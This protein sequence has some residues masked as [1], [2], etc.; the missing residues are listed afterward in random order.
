MVARKEEIQFII[1]NG[2]ITGHVNYTDDEIY[3]LDQVVIPEGVTG[4]G[5]KAL[6]DIHYV[7]LVRIPASVTWIAPD[8]FLFD[9]CFDVSKE[10]EVYASWNGVLYDK[11]FRALLQCPAFIPDEG[12]RVIDR[13]IIP[14]SVVHIGAYAFDLNQI[15][16][17]I[18]PDSVTSIGKLAF[19]GCNLVICRSIELSS[20]LCSNEELTA[21]AAMLVQKDYEMELNPLLK[22]YILYELYCKHPEDDLAMAYIEQHPDIIFT[23]LIDN[24][25]EAELEKLLDSGC[26]HLE[27]CIDA[28]L[29]QAI[30]KRAVNIQLLLMNY[31]NEHIGFSRRLEL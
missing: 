12:N 31:K 10:N 7:G 17:I 23:F 6:L 29:E 21:A 25:K 3:G 15:P 19:N 8:A 27:D 11:Q 4:I 20:L 30:E 13:F 22:G 5:E 16:E 1:E 28:L 24:E 26:F 2:I 9:A 18:V 14:D